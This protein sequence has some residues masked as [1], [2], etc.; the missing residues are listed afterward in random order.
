MKPPQF[1]GGKSEDSHEFLILHHE[2]LEA[3]GMVDARGVCFVTLQLCRP[4]REWWRNYVR[5]R[6]VGYPSTEWV[7]FSSSFQDH[8]IPWSVKEESRLR[9]ESLPQGSSFVSG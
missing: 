2:M 9:F 3:M 5:S 4:T 7:T 1:Q 8:F 6:P